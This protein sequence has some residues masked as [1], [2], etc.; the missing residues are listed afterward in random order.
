MSE[1]L[2]S[3]LG[4]GG[5]A[6]CYTKHTSLKFGKGILVGASCSCPRDGFDIYIGL[7]SYMRLKHQTF[8]WDSEEDSVIEFQVSIV[9]M[10]VPKSSKEFKKMIHWVCSQLHKGKRIHV[11]CIGGHGRTG[12]FI[13]A[14]RAEY[15]GDLDAGN[16][17]RKH[18][19]TRAIESQ[20]QINFLHKHFGITKIKPLKTHYK[21]WVEKTGRTNK[22]KSP[23]S[24]RVHSKNKIIPFTGTFHPPK[25]KHLAGKGSIW[26]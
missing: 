3:T 14:V 12:M 26:G 17:V 18:H 4:S 7:D 22:Y 8:P 2:F 24:S 9:D 16:W 19:C 15:I 13:A 21:G 1:D 6:R 10:G 11:G 23:A 25:L 20:A 5:K